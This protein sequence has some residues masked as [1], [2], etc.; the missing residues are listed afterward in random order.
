VLGP[1]PPPHDGPTVTAPLTMTDEGPAERDGVEAKKIAIEQ[2]ARAL[3]V[4]RQ[5]PGPD[6]RA[7][8]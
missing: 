1:I 6:C 3:E 4:I 5:Q 7:A 8:R 2:L